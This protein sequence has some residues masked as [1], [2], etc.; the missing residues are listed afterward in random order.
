MMPKGIQ[1]ENPD[2]VPNFGRVIVEPLERGWGH[3]VGNALRRI[4][5]YRWRGFSQR[6]W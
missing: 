2:N 1:I 4:R 6:R 5:F 3:T